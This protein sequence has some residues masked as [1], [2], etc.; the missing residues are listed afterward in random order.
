MMDL[1]NLQTSDKFIQR[2]E[3]CYLLDEATSKASCNEVLIAP[4]EIYALDSDFPLNSDWS[5]F[6]TTAPM[7][8]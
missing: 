5:T 1:N 4:D 8:I 3:H 2:I 6:G 7:Q